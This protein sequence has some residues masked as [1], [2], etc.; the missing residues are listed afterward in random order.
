MELN[1]KQ[2]RFIFV[3]VILILIIILTFLS[4]AIATLNNKKNKNI[5]ISIGAN[6]ISQILQKY[7]CTYIEDTYDEKREYQ[8]EIKLIFKHKLY[9]NYE[10]NEKI[11]NNIINDIARF[12]NYTNF[13]MLDKE[14]DITI[15]VICRDRSIYQIIINGIED[16]FIY[17]DSQLEISKYKEIEITNIISNVDVLDYLIENDWTTDITV[18]TR[19]SIFKNYYIFFDE[20]IQYKKIGSDVYN[21]VFTN[22]YTEPVV[23]NIRVGVSLENIKQ[24]LGKPTFEDEELEVIGYKGKNIYVFFT[25]NEISIYK[26]KTYNYDEFWKLIDTFLEDD[27]L[28]KE[29]MNELTY[30]WKDYSEYSYSSDYMFIAYPNRGIE[31]KLNYNNESGIILYNNISEDLKIVKKYLDNTEFLSKLKL[32]SVF[33]AEKRRVEEMKE[34]QEKYIRLEKESNT[35]S[36]LFYTYL[37]KD[38]N[39]NT[40]KVYFISKNGEHPNRELNETVDTYVWTRDNYYVYSIYGKGIYCYDAIN[41]SKFLITDNGSQ[42]FKIKSFENN[43]L[44]YD[45]G[46]IILEY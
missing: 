16:Y 19:E 44:T 12:V 28:F 18:G 38:E 27:M 3:I 1:Q 15:E 34:F 46:Q 37:D 10:S 8:T 11:F 39:N 20:G 17:M 29:F 26:N 45:G 23:N 30:L 21:I 24:S 9:E 43:L 36:F 41:G 7:N 32:D 2:I 25:E 14:N 33:E 42:T 35:K 31:V 40:I 13:K 4:I 5:N 6:S 22:K